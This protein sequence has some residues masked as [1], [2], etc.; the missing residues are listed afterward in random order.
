MQSSQKRRRVSFLVV[1][2]IKSRQLRMKFLS[3][4]TVSYVKNC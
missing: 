3:I 2:V 1:H 4:P